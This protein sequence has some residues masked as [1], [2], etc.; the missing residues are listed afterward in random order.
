MLCPFVVFV[1][2][3]E[4]WKWISDLFIMVLLWCVVPEVYFSLDSF[5]KGKVLI[6]P[7]EIHRDPPYLV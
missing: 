7:Y 4:V 5:R 2:I 6:I 3:T 1:P